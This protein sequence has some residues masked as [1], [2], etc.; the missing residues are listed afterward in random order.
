MDISELSDVQSESGVIGTLIRHPEYVEHSDYL[1][2]NHFEDFNNS[3]MYWAIRELY[4]DGITH[5]DAYNVS[6]KLQS[7]SAIQ[8][9]LSQ[10]NLPS[11]QEQ[12]RLF[13]YTARESLEEY[14]MFAQ[15]VVTYAFKRD[16]V[17]TLQRVEKDCF[18]H[19][20]SLETLN[21]TVYS[22]LDN[23][24]KKYLMTSEVQ[25]LGDQL[26]DIWNEIISRRTDDGMYGMPS[27]YKSFSN[28]FTY[29]PGELFV[30]QAKYKQGKSV[31]LMNE[32]VHKLKNGVAS[33]VIDREMPTRLYTERLL[34]HL[35]GI[36]VNRIKNGRYS[37]EEAQELKKWMDWLKKQPFIHI[38]DPDMSMEKIFS[39]CRMLQNKMNLGFVVYDY[40]KSNETSTSDNYNILGAKCDFLKN[41]IAGKLNLPVLAAC[42]LNRNGEVQ[43]SIKINQYLSVAIKWGYKTQ[44]MIARDGIQC[45]NAYAKIEINR[46]GRH[47]P[48]DDDQYIDFTFNGDTMTIVEAEQHEISEDY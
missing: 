42:Q 15:N 30:V 22:Q 20:T 46:L 37:S 45:G 11:I 13:E 47:H 41:Q 7:Y 3:C 29:E 19:D 34:S 18:Q 21:H 5:I 48:E 1:Q 26:D 4:N 25:T 17:T 2:P 24:T 6:N 43:D 14:H 35:S 12:M 16:L 38:Y 27:K 33:L 23:L 40:L 10:Y 39:L 28:F 9:N 44:E 31:F 36:D 8:K 32:V